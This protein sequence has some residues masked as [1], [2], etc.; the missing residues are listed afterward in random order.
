[1]IDCDRL[2]EVPA[3]SHCD[4]AYVDRAAGW[5]VQVW[6]NA[7]PLCDGTPWEGSKRVAIKHTRAKTRQNALKRGYSAPVEWDDMQAI[8]NHFWSGQIGIEVFPPE[9]DL[10]DVANMRW[11]WI[12]PV[13]ASLPFNLADE[14]RPLGGDPCE[15]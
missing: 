8:K 3:G 2:V 13:G 6:N 14:K 5:C 7:T 11:M 1:M 10:V 12:L 4:R 15:R 9:S